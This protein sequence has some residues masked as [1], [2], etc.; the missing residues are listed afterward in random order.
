MRKLLFAAALLFSSQAHA[1]HTSAT[2]LGGLMR[3]LSISHLKLCER[4]GRV[5]GEGHDFF[6]SLTQVLKGKAASL[7][8]VA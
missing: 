2:F 7:N 5:E 4:L 6:V 8:G 1:S 3:I